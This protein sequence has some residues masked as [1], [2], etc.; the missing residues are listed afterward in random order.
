MQIHGINGG[1]HSLKIKGGTAV[2]EEVMIKLQAAVLNFVSDISSPICSSISDK[3]DE[4]EALEPKKKQGSSMQLRTR[5]QK[6]ALDS[7]GGGTT[8]KSKATRS[9]V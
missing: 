3:V 6:R 4:Q 7:D 5:K 8:K 9:K 1:D 2:N